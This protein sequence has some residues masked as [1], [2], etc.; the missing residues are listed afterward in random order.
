MLRS[1]RNHRLRRK[2]GK[3]PSGTD[4]LSLYE[5]YVQGLRPGSNNNYTGFCPLHGETPGKST[6]SLSVN[7]DTGLWYCF[8][9]CGGG[10]ARSFLEELG[11]NRS[12]IDLKIATLPKARK[13]KR[14]RYKE[15]TVLPE[16]L[17]GVFDYCPTSLLR[18]GF[19]EKILFEHDVGYDKELERITF[20]IRTRS[21]ELVG[22]VGRRQ[23]PEFG[24]YKVYTRELLKY[25]F[26][27]PSL[28]KTDYLWRGD[29]V[30]PALGRK[31]DVYVV[32][33]FKAALWFVQSGVEMVV[34]LMGSHMSEKQQKEIETYGQRVILC[35]DNDVAGQKATL[36]ISHKLSAMQRYVVPLPEGI[37]QPDDLTEEELRDLCERPVTISEVKR[38]WQIYR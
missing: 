2:R 5:E 23:N 14:A 19:E 18:A 28:A 35:L 36:N 26:N 7:I 4:F 24:K 6:P 27:V 3:I 12:K 16:K 11:E 9:G 13:Q 29:K 22:I 37:H 21:G 34:A 10:H 17:L 33:G 8:A 1:L 15:V 38:K 31:T 20:P 32:E 30:Y 25:G